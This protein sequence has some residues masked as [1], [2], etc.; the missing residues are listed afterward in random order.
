MRWLRLSFRASGRA[1]HVSLHG[2]WTWEANSNAGC[3]L[4]LARG[5]G[6]CRVS[7]PRWRCRC[8]RHSGRRGSRGHRRHGLRRWSP[9][10]ATDPD[11]GMGRGGSTGGRRSLAAACSR[12][13][14]GRPRATMLGA[15]C[16]GGSNRPTC[17]ECVT[18]L[19]GGPSPMDEGRSSSSGRLMSGGPAHLIRGAWSCRGVRDDGR[20][21]QSPGR[22]HREVHRHDGASRT[23][24]GGQVAPVRWS[25]ASGMAGAS[26]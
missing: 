17:E 9:E 4:R 11:P 24:R 13:T 5:R 10:V 18:S 2:G 14:D 21:V 15:A 3:D 16:S 22:A 23:R 26:R 19:V 6:S 12:H 1:T 20:E 7:P 25:R 8:G